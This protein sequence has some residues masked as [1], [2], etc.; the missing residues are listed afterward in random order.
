MIDFKKY[1]GIKFKVRSFNKDEG[2]DCLTF[3]LYFL[4][5]EYNYNFDISTVPDYNKYW[6]MDKGLRG[7]YLD[8]VKH[9]CALKPYKE[10]VN[11]K[12]GQLLFFSYFNDAKAITHAGIY[13]GNNNFIHCTEEVGVCITKVSNYKK[14]LKWIGDINGKTI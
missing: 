6:Y 4:K 13:V 7:L 1:E 9:Y 12:I 3:I 5:Q 14:A 2:L 8:S 11:I 10:G